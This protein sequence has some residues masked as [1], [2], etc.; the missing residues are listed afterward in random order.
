MALFQERKNKHS[1]YLN[2]VTAVLHGHGGW[3]LDEVH[4]KKYFGSELD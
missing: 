1:K 3:E 4:I 2:L